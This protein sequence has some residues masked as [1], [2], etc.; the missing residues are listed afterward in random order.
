MRVGLPDAIFV[1]CRFLDQFTQT[2]HSIMRDDG[3]LPLPW[4]NY[5]ALLVRMLVPCSCVLA[6]LQIVCV[7]RCAS[8]GQLSVRILRVS[9]A[10]ASGSSSRL[11]RRFFSALLFPLPLQA[12]ARHRCEYLVLW[13]EYEFL[14]NGGTI[15]PSA[16]SAA[17]RCLAFAAAPVLGM[18]H[19]RRSFGSFAC[20][21]ANS[22]TGC[23]VMVYCGAGDASW[24]KGGVKATPKKLQVSL[25]HLSVLIRSFGVLFE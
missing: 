2:T 22:Q 10:M 15:I 23:D 9:A 17:A 14:A 24:L 16:C 19:A 18:E 12:A 5:I 20:S 21:S 11:R 1:D 4:R 13:Q 25:A 8:V 7:P 6:A 3:P